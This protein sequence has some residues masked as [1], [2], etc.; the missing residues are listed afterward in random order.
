MTRHSV[1]KSTSDSAVV[2]KTSSHTKAVSYN[3][4]EV[5]KSQNQHSNSSQDSKFFGK[6]ACDRI[7]Q[8]IISE[9]NPK[10]EQSKLSK[11]VPL[12]DGVVLSTS[13][14]QELRQR[15]SHQSS[16]SLCPDEVKCKSTKDAKL[17]SHERS[18][19][20][21]PNDSSIQEVS[22]KEAKEIVKNSDTDNRKNSQTY[23][24]CW[25]ILT[26]LSLLSRLYNIEIPSHVW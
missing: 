2:V 23:Y 7:N 6:P 18:E 19:N 21:K 9:G 4:L 5:L 24:L 11:D 10:M 14:R 25:M 3:R 12:K 16:I 8:C 20:L 15:R 22:K 13:N 26:L 1:D 17:S